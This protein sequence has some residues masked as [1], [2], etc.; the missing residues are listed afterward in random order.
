MTWAR[1]GFKH[2]KWN[3]EYIYFIFLFLEHMKEKISQFTKNFQEFEPE[4]IKEKLYTFIQQWSE[5]TKSILESDNLVIQRDGNDVPEEES[6]LNSNSWVE[7]ILN[8]NEMLKSGVDK[9]EVKPELIN[10]K[11]FICTLIRLY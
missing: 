9:L 4:L 11:S 6:F 5:E 7:V 10:S 8:L 2:Q 3:W 1:H